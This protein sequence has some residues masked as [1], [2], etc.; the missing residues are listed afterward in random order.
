V[1]GTSGS[2]FTMS[3]F[4]QLVNDLGEIIGRVGVPTA[5]ATRPIIDGIQF[6]QNCS[7]LSARLSQDIIDGNVMPQVS[8]PS[9][10]IVRTD[11]CGW[12]SA[13]AVTV[14]SGGSDADRACLEHAQVDCHTDPSIIAGIAFGVFLLLIMMVGLVIH[15]RV[16]SGG[17]SY[18]A[19][20]SLATDGDAGVYAARVLSNGTGSSLYQGGDGNENNESSQPTV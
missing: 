11:G 1:P 20:G 18:H 10:S 15:A 17:P 3:V 9:G 12:L 14:F 16:S 6:P 19:M 4:F 2:N 13:D 5:D 7:D 8:V